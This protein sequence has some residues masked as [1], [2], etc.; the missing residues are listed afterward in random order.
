MADA[1]AAHQ[2]KGASVRVH[3]MPAPLS[4]TR[5]IL[6]FRHSSQLMAESFQLTRRWLA[7]ARPAVTY[8]A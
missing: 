7:E 8:A 2:S 1:G 4:P 6:D 3:L 5:N